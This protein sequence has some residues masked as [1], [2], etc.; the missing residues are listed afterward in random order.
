MKKGNIKPVIVLL[1]LIVVLFLVLVITNSPKSN[2]HKFK[3][4]GYSMYPGLNSGNRIKIDYDYYVKNSIL[5][6]DIVAIKFQTRDETLI[7]R[8]IALPGDKF[9]IKDNSIYLN[10][11]PLV[12]PYVGDV[13]IDLEGVM[14]LEKQLERYDGHVPINSFIVLGDNRA[15]SFDSTDFGVVDKEQIVGKVII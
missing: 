8:V 10:G 3:L 14:L 1:N 11:K 5:K 7:K 9:E 4:I 15:A 2:T 12:E 6:G 13:Q